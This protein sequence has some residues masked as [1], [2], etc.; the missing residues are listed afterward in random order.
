MPYWQRTTK[1]DS[2]W[3]K[4]GFCQA[5][6]ERSRLIIEGDIAISRTVYPTY[7]RLEREEQELRAI[8]QTWRDRGKADL[9]QAIEEFANDC[10]DIWDEFKEKTGEEQVDEFQIDLNDPRI[11]FYKLMDSD[12]GLLCAPGVTESTMTAETPDWIVM[13]NGD[14]SGT[15]SVYMG[16]KAS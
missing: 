2:Q 8:L 7:Q 1:D 11:T 13:P 12:S 3:A 9:A 14:W 15:I 5:I 16:Q 6:F 4:L 10:G